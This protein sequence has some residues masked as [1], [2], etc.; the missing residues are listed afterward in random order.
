MN[1]PEK[2]GA[3]QSGG[4]IGQSS[5]KRKIPKLPRKS[6]LKGAY[7]ELKEDVDMLDITI[8]PTIMSELDS[9]ISDMG[10]AKIQLGLFAEFSNEDGEV[11]RWN[12]SNKAVEFSSTFYEEGIAALDAKIAKYTNN[13]SSWHLVKILQV[14][15]TVTKIS[16]M[17]NLSGS[18][19]IQTPDNLAASKS[20]VNVKNHDSFCFL[21]GILAVQHY[22]DIAANR[23]RVTNYNL[24]GK[25]FIF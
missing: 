24:N 5:R 16:R 7:V 10:E 15:M 1:K 8:P 14:N 19:Y 17:I 4:G 11:R 22:G 23:D 18:S 13:S 9:L 2:S 21:Y 20:V 12:F 25:L 6:T 3:V